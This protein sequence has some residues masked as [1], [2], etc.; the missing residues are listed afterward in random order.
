MRGGRRGTGQSEGPGTSQFE[1]AELHDE[2]AV[3]DKA[4]LFRRSG[5]ELVLE[6]GRGKS[7]MRGTWPP[8]TRRE[9]GQ[10]DLGGRGDGES[11]GA[12]SLVNTG[13]GLLVLRCNA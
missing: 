10:S 4:D 1:W 9:G 12:G 5:H 3:V 8:R 13:V 11:L 6:C 7:D 2:L